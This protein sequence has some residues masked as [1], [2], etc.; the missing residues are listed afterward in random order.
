MKKL[1]P[2]QVARLH[3]HLIQTGASDALINEL[4]DH[5]GCEIEHYL[6]K[7]YPFE[8]ALAQAIREADG[9]TVRDLSQRYQHELRL[10]DA[11]LQEASLDD[12]VFQFRNK[13]YGAYDLRQA[14]PKNLRNA[15]LIA[16]G[17]CMMLMALMQMVSQHS[18]SYWSPWGAVWLLGLGAVTFASVSWYLQHQK[19]LSIR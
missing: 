5:L 9:G 15:I 11:Q 12:I 7:G 3:E 14:Y 13:S 8:L 17:L 6:W 19:E 16:L 10:T 2:Q 4:I 1:N 18:W